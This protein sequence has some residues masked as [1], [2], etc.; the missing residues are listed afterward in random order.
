LG[1]VTASDETNSDKRLLVT[2]SQNTIIDRNKKVKIRSGYTRLG[3]GNASETPIRN[4]FTWHNSSG[5]ELP[6]RFY[7]DEW[8]VYLGTIDG[9]AINAWTRIMSSMSTTAIPRGDKWWNNTEGLDQM[10]MVQ[11]DDNLYIWNGAIAIVDSIT[12]TTI[13]KTGTP[14]FAESRFYTAATKV[15]VCIRTGTEYT[16]TGGETTTTLTGIADTA[17]LVAGDIL[18]QKIITDSNAVASGRTNH[19]IWNFENQICLGSDDD[20]LVYISKSADYSD[21]T[22]STP[23]VS[24]EGGL[25]TLQDPVKAFGTLGNNLVISCGRDSWFKA[26][27]TQITVSTTLAETLTIEKLA[28]GVD[29]G[30]F[31]QETMVQVGDSLIYLSHEPAVRMISDPSQIAGLDPK[32]LSN[33]IKPDFDAEDWTNACATW[34]KNAYYLSAP[35]NSKLYILEFIENANGQLQRYWNP[36][37]ILPVRALAIISDWIHG[38]SNG[39]PETYKLFD[40][41]SDIVPEGTSGE[42]DDKLPV[43][44]V[45]AFA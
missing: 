8:E 35:A 43:K 30:A 18:I 1:Y 25:L 44:A 26:E 17:G 41:T 20:N 11:G 31:N 39:V 42:P 3:A 14:T 38:H 34:Y 7:D 16:Y 32:T 29:Q 13:T 37:Q 22:F 10:I 9:T 15:L 23:R 6:L 12:G 36:P 27:Y 40:G 21:F 24:G 4:S 2:G 33:P 28:V 45:A 5:V 19:T